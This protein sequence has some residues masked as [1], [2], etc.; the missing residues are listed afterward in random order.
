MIGADGR[1]QRAPNLPR[2]G[3]RAGGRRAVPAPGRGAGARRE[4]GRPGRAGRAV[5]RRRRGR[6]RRPADADF[7]FVSGGIGVGA[8]IVLGGELFRGAGGRAGELGH[9]VVDPDGPRVQL[10]RPRLPGAGRRAGGAAAGGRRGDG[11]RSCSPG[12]RRPIEP[13]G[14]ALGV[15]LTGAVHLLDVRTVVLGGLY[16]QLGDGLRDAV[17][18]RAGGPGR[19][20][21]GAA[22][23]AGHRGRAARRRGLG[24][25][26]GCAAPA[27]D[28]ASAQE[29]L[30]STRTRSAVIVVPSG[31]PVTATRSPTARLRVHRGHV[32]RHRQPVAL[33]DGDRCRR[34]AR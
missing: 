22:A 4:R 10:R 5:V 15:A 17:A 33:Q 24:G 1:L 3:R 19:A 14:R 20:G 7:L 28:R 13:A 21:G 25:A 18:A 8:G 23:A 31:S 16:A 6:R 34:P 32:H 26:G 27:A 11:R 29:A 2:L 30:G 12:R 9:V